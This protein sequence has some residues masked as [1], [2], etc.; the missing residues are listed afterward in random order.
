M[1]YFVLHDITPASR[2][3][4]VLQ[5]YQTH[6]PNFRYFLYV[7]IVFSL[8]KEHMPGFDYIHGLQNIQTRSYEETIDLFAKASLTIYK[9]RKI[10]KLPNTYLWILGPAP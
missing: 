4:S 3:I 6:F 8:N 7:D 2:C 9:E 5:N 10:E 1:Q